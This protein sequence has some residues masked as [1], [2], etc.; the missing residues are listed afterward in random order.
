MEFKAWPKILRPENEEFYVTEKIDGTNACVVIS[1]TGEIAAQSRKNII[2]PESD[3]FGFA[4]W[5]QSNKDELLKLGPGHHYGEWWG[6]KIQRQYGL[7]HKRFSLFSW[8][9]EEIPE[10]CHRIPL[11]SSKAKREDFTDILDDLIKNG[12]KAAPGFM[13]IEGIVVFSKYS[14]ARY[15]IIWRK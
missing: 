10:C 12:S 5:V 14:Q 11:L 1:D 15:K 8:W 13:N 6:H 3:N 2:T 4:A 7:D 9:T